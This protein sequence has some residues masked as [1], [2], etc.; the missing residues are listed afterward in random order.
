MGA[1]S[2]VTMV[3]RL[4][5]ACVLLLLA[6]RPGHGYELVDRLRPFGFDWSGQGPVYDQLKGLEGAGLVSSVLDVVNKG[7]GARRVYSLT[8]AGVQELE[9][10]ESTLTELRD[11]LEGYLGR[12]GAVG[13]AGPG[14]AAVDA[15]HPD[16]GDHLA[17]ARDPDAVTGV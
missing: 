14:R 9:S 3:P 8:P 16:G 12:V 13:A 2:I 6:E 17:A 4:L 5:P 11:L 10:W 15:A 7:G 1:P